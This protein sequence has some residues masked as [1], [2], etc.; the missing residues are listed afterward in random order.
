MESL[1]HNVKS[2]LKDYGSKKKVCGED[3]DNGGVGRMRIMEGW[4]G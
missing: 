3:E 1:E 4:G 2:L